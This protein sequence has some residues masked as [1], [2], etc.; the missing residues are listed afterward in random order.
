M[1][2]SQPEWKRMKTR[3][4]SWARMVCT[5]LIELADTVSDEGACPLC[6]ARMPIVSIPMHIERGCPPPRSKKINGAGNQ[7][8]DWKKVFAGAGLGK[9]K[10]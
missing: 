8:A 9:E 10:E 4:V 7:K 6:S 2:R 1:R 5:I 3:A